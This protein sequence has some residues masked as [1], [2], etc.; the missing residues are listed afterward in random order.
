MSSNIG[1][2]IF[3]FVVCVVLNFLS[4][5]S[6]CAQVE[7]EFVGVKK[8]AICHTKP[9]QGEQFRIWQESKHAKAFEVLGTPE[10]KAIGVKWGVEN[11]QQ[12][13]KCLTCHSTAYGFSEKR[14]TE[15]ITVEEGVSCESC[16]GPGKDYMKKSVMEDKKQAVEGGLIIPNEK[17][18]FKC[19]NQESPTF[20]PFD[21]KE[22]WEKIKHPVPRK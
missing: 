20:K 6:A 2:T 5:S 10:A 16:H 1:K 18:C 7:R 14:V 15:A 3:I 12:S 13:G 17:T 11:P 19:H 8:C 9:E 22:H 4:L 21:F